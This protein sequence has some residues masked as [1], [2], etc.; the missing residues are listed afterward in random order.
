MPIS[1]F[2]IKRLLKA[3]RALNRYDEDDIDVIRYFLELYLW[4]IEKLIYL[5]V[6]FI[7]LGTGLQFF[8]CIIAIATIR[9]L[10]GGF[11]ASTAMR[12]FYWT[13]LGFMLAIWILPL[14]TINSVIIVCIGVFSVVSTIVAAPTRSKQMERIA[15]KDK[16]NL[17]RNIATFITVIWFI[18]LFVYQDHFLSVPLIWIIFLQNFQLIAVWLSRKIKN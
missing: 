5:I 12:C 13:L 2:F 18:I 8:V 6:I 16:D 15:N 3:Y 17:Y 4:E 10:A 11:H 9:P 14:I 7:A 1:N